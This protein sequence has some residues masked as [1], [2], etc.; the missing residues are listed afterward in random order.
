MQLPNLVPTS[1]EPSARRLLS[2]PETSLL[3]IHESI[4]HRRHLCDV[5]HVFLPK[6]G[7]LN[8]PVSFSAQARELN[9]K[10][11]PRES[12]F[13][14]HASDGRTGNKLLDFDA[15]G[16]DDKRF[17]TVITEILADV[18]P[19]VPLEK[20]SDRFLTDPFPFALLVAFLHCWFLQ[21]FG[22]LLPRESQRPTVTKSSA[23]CFSVFPSEERMKTLRKG[24]V[25][26]LNGN[27]GNEVEKFRNDADVNRLC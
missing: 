7:N 27:G 1:G 11:C 16:F 14:E 20:P 6:Q 10:V 4:S 19:A 9:M 26:A 3:L 22:Q 5:R 2:F 12:L 23:S 15:V 24:N 18:F 17:G 25:G 13:H 21:Q 8:N